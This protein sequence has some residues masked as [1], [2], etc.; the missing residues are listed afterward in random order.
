MDAEQALVGATLRAFCDKHV[1]SAWQHL[2]SPDT[3]LFEPLWEGLAEMGVT[4]LGLPEALGGLALEPRAHFDILHALGAACPALGF[5]LISHV[6]SVSLLCAAARNELPPR[7]ERVIADGRFALVGSPLDR[8]PEPRFEVRMNGRISVTGATRA[9][10]PYADWLVIP[11][12]AESRLRL[13]V[14]RP[15]G[16]AV[17]FRSQA[18][19]HGLRLVPFGELLLDDATVLE[20]CVFD[21]PTDAR[22]ARFADGLLAALM[23]GMLSQLMQIAAGYAVE[24]FQGGK[25]IHEHDA[26]QQ[27]LGPIELSR[28]CL[29]AIA[30]S[31]LALAKPGDGGASAFGVELL[32]RSGLD[33][34][35]VLGGYGYME[36]YRVERTL[37][38]ANT[39][40]TFW[41]HS[42][43]RQ[44]AIARQYCAE[45]SE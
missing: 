15:D 40:E 31:T 33:A 34:I 30:E 19:G 35:Q 29:G 39:L 26:V 17:R 37:R 20:D 5:A 43:Q 27:L 9:A 18:S 16:G 45:L 1:E 11:M 36:E 32:R 7:L 10:I 2:D 41:I 21:W 6:H 22:F 12:Q 44:R 25:L 38:D 42:A 4:G 8:V 23:T 13:C 14:L 3:P 28:R 24:R